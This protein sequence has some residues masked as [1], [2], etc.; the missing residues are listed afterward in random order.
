[1][2]NCI[3]Y[4]LSYMVPN[5]P[6]SYKVTCRIGHLDNQITYDG[7]YGGHNTQAPYIAIDMYCY[8]YVH[9][10]LFSR[11]KNLLKCEGSYALG[12]D[13]DR[14]DL[15]I[16]PTIVTDVSTTDAIM[17]EEVCMAVCY[18]HFN[19]MLTICIVYDT[20]TCMHM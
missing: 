2:D 19:V 9:N 1:M 11:L 13:T 6:L 14:D 3:L 8:T 17:C 7:S 20:H 5:V 12:G 15:Y 10:A 16:A 18:V 4:T